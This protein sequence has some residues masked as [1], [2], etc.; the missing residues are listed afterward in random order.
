MEI[1]FTA[2]LSQYTNLILKRP[3]QAN[4]IHSLMNRVGE[5][6]DQ[7]FKSLDLQTHKLDKHSLADSLDFI[8]FPQIRARFRTRLEGMNDLIKEKYLNAH[9]LDREV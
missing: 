6:L 1:T 4:L 5:R 3:Q 7:V 8:N 9:G 2:F